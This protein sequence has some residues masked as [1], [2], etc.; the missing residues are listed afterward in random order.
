MVVSNLRIL[1]L[2]PSITTE[3]ERDLYLSSVKINSACFRSSCILIVPVAES[4]IAVLSAHCPQISRCRSIRN[5]NVITG[6][7]SH[8]E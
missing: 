5:S 1:I 6:T 7:R 4:H 3:I 8:R 2:Y